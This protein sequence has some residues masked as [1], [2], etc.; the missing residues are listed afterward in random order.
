[1]WMVEIILLIMMIVVAG[2]LLGGHIHNMLN[3]YSQNTSTCCNK[4]ISA[5][6]LGNYEWENQNWREYLTAML[7]LNLISTLV[8]LLALMYQSWLPFNYHLFADIEFPQA[9]NIA[10]SYITTTNWQDFSGEYTLT[11]FIQTVIISWM[12]FIGAASGVCLAVAFMRGLVNNKTVIDGRILGNYWY[13]MRA[14]V[15]Y[16]LLPI[17]F[18]LSLILIWQGTPQQLPSPYLQIKTLEGITQIIPKG[19]IASQEAIK[20]FGV[21]GGGI[22]GAS[23]AHPFENPT[24]FSNFIQIVA[25]AAIGCALWFTFG[26][27]NKNMKQSWMVIIAILIMI[28]LC[29]IGNYLAEADNI[30]EIVAG[31]NVTAGNLEGKEVRFGL[32]MT[33]AYSIISCS[34]SGSANSVYDSFTPIG[35]MFLLVDI[36]LGGVLFGG[37]G[38]GFTAMLMFVILAVFISGL[39][40]GK[41]PEYLG[42]KITPTDIRLVMLYTA[43]FQCS[44]MLMS[45]VSVYYKLSVL[46]PENPSHQI[47]EI[48]Y[49]LA[50]SVVNNGT[51]FSGLVVTESWFYHTLSALM[52][53]GRYALFG[54][55]FYISHSFLDRE[56][57]RYSG[58]SIRPEKPIFIFV[59]LFT[60]FN[61][62][63]VFIPML[64]VGPI[65]ELTTFIYR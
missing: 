45:V 21:N 42:K 44:I 3:L 33:S 59:L 19:F 16:V 12:G 7:S 31:I 6:L 18:V 51:G 2:K 29:F 63:L 43:F 55:A 58:K 39:I 10:I 46:E 28:A 41:S 48:I 26:H 38:D 17:C 23:S 65:A 11:P 57:S 64:I 47:T 25:M 8:C 13:D 35:G 14:T 1:M 61:S 32:P 54:L 30:G 36:L 15:F 62:S 50:S 56:V 52:F 37:N 9:L 40:V 20:V 49:A 34:T 22:F 5:V 53:V 24:P 4:V 27:I 60:I